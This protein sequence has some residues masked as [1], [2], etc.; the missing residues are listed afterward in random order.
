MK[1][2]RRAYGSHRVMTPTQKARNVAASIL[3]HGLDMASV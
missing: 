2:G 1:F 3:M